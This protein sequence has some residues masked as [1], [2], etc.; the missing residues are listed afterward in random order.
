MKKRSHRAD[1]MARVYDDE[2]LPIWSHRFG[3]MLLRDL[4]LPPKAMVLDVACG[5][6]YPAL[7]L[8]NLMQGQGRI[9]A[10]ESMGALLDVA[11]QKAG[12][13]SG[14]RIFFRSEPATAKLAFASEVYDL[15]VSNLGLLEREDPAEALKELARVTK[16]GGRVI[17]TLPL[18]GSFAEFYDI[19]REVLVKNDKHEALERLERHI[20]ETPDA[21]QAARWMEQS[22]LE[23]VQ[24]EMEEFNLLFQ[25]AREF[26]FA[27]VIEY[28]PLTAWKEVIGKGQEMQDIF[29]QIKEAIDAYFG[30]RAF[31]VTIKAGCLRGRK[32]EQPAE[33]TRPPLDSVDRTPSLEVVAAVTGTGPEQRPAAAAGPGPGPGKDFHLDE[34]EESHEGE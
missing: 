8:L 14:K 3:R 33:A 12:A 22:G 23:D 13:L 28:G 20:L 26:F 18:L 7:E 19:Y 1:K 5:T 2:I 15:V 30:E 21:E 29:W 17:V 27:P 31:G 16:A 11:R 9:V 32:G 25:S 24:V 10:I 4:E 6:G 34:D